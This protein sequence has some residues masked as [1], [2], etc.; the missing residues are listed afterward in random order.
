VVLRDV[1]GGLLLRN[2]HR[3]VLGECLTVAEAASDGSLRQLLSA[4]GAVVRAAPRWLRE[5]R[6]I[7]QSRRVGRHELARMLTPGHPGLERRLGT[8]AGGR[9]RRVVSSGARE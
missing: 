3:I 8:V 6:S 1:P 9:R 4:Y 5:R 2:A 7:Q